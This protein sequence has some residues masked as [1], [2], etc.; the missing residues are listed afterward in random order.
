MRRRQISK[1][2][3]EKDLDGTTLSG[4]ILTRSA[5]LLTSFRLRT[6]LFNLEWKIIYASLIQALFLI[7]K[8]QHK[9]AY[10]TTINNKKYQ[11][12]IT[13]TTTHQSLVKNHHKQSNTTTMKTSILICATCFIVT[14]CSA[15][16]RFPSLSSALS[17]L[18]GFGGGSSSSGSSSSNG[19]SGQSSSPYSGL[20]RDYGRNLMMA[21]SSIYPT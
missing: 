7:Y 6:V 12:S 10:L 11:T 21:M 19:Q 3:L 1:S 8:Q 9:S 15:Q 2:R 18:T 17:S 5:R 14:G 13:T 20:V 4:F 16:L